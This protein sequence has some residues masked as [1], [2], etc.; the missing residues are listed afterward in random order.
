MSIQKVNAVCVLGTKGINDN[1]EKLVYLPLI[2]RTI[3][4]VQTCRALIT[5]QI[6]I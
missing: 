1:L 5:Y 6:F 3:D 4:D 2:V